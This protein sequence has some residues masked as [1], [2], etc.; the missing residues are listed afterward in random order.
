MN[1][2]Y[3]KPASVLSHG[4]KTD[5][6]FAATLAER[7]Q[8]HKAEHESLYAGTPEPEGA[9]RYAAIPA[10]IEAWR[11]TGVGPKTENGSA[12]IYLESDNPRFYKVATPEMVIGL[13]PSIG[14][15]WVEGID[16]TYLS[17]KADFE[18][19]F[20]AVIVGGNNL[21]DRHMSSFGMVPGKPP[22]TEDAEYPRSLHSTKF[23]G[24]QIVVN[25]REEHD[26]AIA[27]GWADMPL[28][29]RPP[30]KSEVK[31]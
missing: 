19:D 28:E 7:N 27:S 6:G 4:G 18:R 26:R 29:N 30:E 9:V 12:V 16:K 13:Y 5:D 20:K 17:L 25:N 23:L 31:P 2:L 15:Y 1:S 14:D 22:S 11:I 24:D 21:P 10:T 3:D 8:H